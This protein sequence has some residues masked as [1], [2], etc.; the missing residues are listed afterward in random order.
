M[1]ENVHEIRWNPLIGTWVIVAGHRG[2]RPWRPTEKPSEAKTCPF[3]P[4]SPETRGFGEWDVIVLPNKYPAL[5]PSAHEPPNPVEDIYTSMA[6]RGYCEVLVE[7]PK[8]TGDLHDLSMEHMLKVVKKYRDEYVRLSRIDFIK[9][10]AI[11]RNKGKEI[12][13]SLVHPHSQIYAL[14]F[15]PPRII[16][17]LDN[18]RRFYRERNECLL[19]HIIELERERRGGNRIIYENRDF[20]LIHPYYAMWP[21]ELHIYPKRHVEAI[22]GLTEGELRS[23]SDILRMTTA[24]YNGLFDR[25][26]PYIMAMHSSPC[27]D[28]EYKYYHFHIEFYQPYRDRDKLKYRAGIETGFWVFT[29]DGDPEEKR[30]ELRSSCFKV[31]E[32][33]DHIGEC[34]E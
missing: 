10:V 8:H 6:A 7:T 4:G 30:E 33:L 20:V 9:Y 2:S 32:K 14:P 34:V 31:S 5:K 17:E 16:V 23:L 12:G 22:D 24:I 19:C 27:D 11:F 3:C 21:Y 18:F 13:V 1:R 28:Y 25:D 29:F 15:I 26:M